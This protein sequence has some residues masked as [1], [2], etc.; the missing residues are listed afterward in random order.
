MYSPVKISARRDPRAA[1]FAS[2]T[3]EC[4]RSEGVYQAFVGF[5]CFQIFEFYTTYRLESANIKYMIP[6]TI[7]RNNILNVIK[8]LA[9]VKTRNPA[10]AS[11]GGRA[12][13]A[14]GIARWRAIFVLLAGGYT[15]VFRAF[16]TVRVFGTNIP[17]S[18]EF[19]GSRYYYQLRQV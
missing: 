8:R 17:E 5:W 10:R 4:P 13:L 7:P 2:G 14:V 18:I 11:F 1:L 15:Y 12:M 9:F 19:S 16:G 6:P 3:R